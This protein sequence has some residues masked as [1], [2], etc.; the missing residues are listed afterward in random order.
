MSRIILFAVC[1]L[2]IAACDS[3][4]PA[5]DTLLEKEVPQ[6]T[7]LAGK[8]A[9]EERTI[10]IYKSVTCGCCSKWA[11]HLE[12]N[13]FRVALHDTEALGE[14]KSKYGVPDNMRACHTAT[15][16]EYIIEGH[17]PASDIDELLKIK[18]PQRILAVPGMPFG[19]PGMEHPNKSTPYDS[20][21]IGQD[22]SVTVFERH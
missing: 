13:G 20:L 12:K 21:L 9:D 11:D 16:D 17:V 3:G 14:I 2:L 1:T 10:T 5:K 6:V 18:P 19:S 4:E 22:G 15:I 7:N 8:V